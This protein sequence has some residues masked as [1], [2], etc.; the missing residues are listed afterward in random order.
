MHYSIFRRIRDIF[1]LYIL[2]FLVKIA[3][4]RTVTYI[5][6]HSQSIIHELDRSFIDQVYTA[7]R[8]L[9][10]LQE[11]PLYMDAHAITM[12]EIGSELTMIEEKY[13]KNSLGLAFLGP[14][15][16]T[17]IVTKEEELQK[18]L[19]LSINDLGE[20]LNSIHNKQERFSPAQTIE[21]GLD[22]NKQLLQTLGNV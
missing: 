11:H 21:N 8:Q 6:M 1:F 12:A 7:Q 9:H 16:S 4:D 20:I 17:A 10:I 18:K 15:G 2:I 3:F 13:K 19:L 14:I 5:E 22:S